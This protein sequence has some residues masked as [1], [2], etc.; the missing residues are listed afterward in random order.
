LHTSA[1]DGLDLKNRNINLLKAI[2]LKEGF[3]KGVR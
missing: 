1:T 2:L 3:F